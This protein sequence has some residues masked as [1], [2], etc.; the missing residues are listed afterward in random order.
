M[1]NNSALLKQAKETEVSVDHSTPTKGGGPRLPVEGKCPARLIGYVELGVHEQPEYKGQAKDPVMEVQLTFEC[2]GKD[3]MDELEVD[4]VKK[5]VGRIVRPL[6]M[7]MKV[8]ERA[9]F[10]KLFKAMDYGRD[11]D[12]MSKMINDV[13]RLTISHG[14]SK[15]GT[16]YA[17]IDIIESPV[18]EKFDD[19]GNVV[20]ST[21][22]SAKVPP[23][24]YDLQLFIVEKPTFEQW[25]SIE[26][27]GTYNRKT[28]AEDGTELEEEVSKNFLQDKIKNSVDWEGSAMQALLLDVGQEDGDEEEEVEEKKPE[29]TSKSSSKKS[30]AKS[31]KSSSETVK[32]EDASTATSSPSEEDDMDA[33]LEEIGL[34]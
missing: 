26:I 20:G 33:M 32:E 13:F 14:E 28:K 3:N 15:K 8:D 27:K 4:G 21:D 17:T 19:E 24:S 9:K 2:F 6:P 5:K 7:T 1:S 25:G 29:S 22:I 11:L 23:A 16:K 10:F 30:S 18:I 12:H 34:S 31:A